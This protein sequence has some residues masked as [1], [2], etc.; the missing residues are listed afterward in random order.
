MG[1]VPHARRIERRPQPLEPLR[2][3]SR[4]RSLSEARLRSA[5]LFETI[6]K[7]AVSKRRSN[8]KVL[9]AVSVVFEHAALFHC[10]P[11]GCDWSAAEAPLQ[12]GSSSYLVQPES[13]RTVRRKA[14][15]GFRRLNAR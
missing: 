9:V 5:P 6:Q 1:N 4:A 13:I 15:T 12:T 11:R 10:L 7:S 8:P 14:E 3:R 2:R